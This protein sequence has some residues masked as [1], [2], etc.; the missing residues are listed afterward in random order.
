MAAKVGSVMT[1]AVGG[2]HV[3]GTVRYIGPLAEDV[4]GGTW[5]GVEL[6]EP[7]GRHSG[8]RYFACAERH[9]LFVRA[10]AAAAAMVAHLTS[11]PRGPIY[12]QYE[13]GI[14]TAAAASGVPF[15]MPPPH[16][17]GAGDALILIDLQYDYLPGG[18]FGVPEGNDVL[19]S[20]AGLLT[21]GAAA[22]ATVVCTREYH[23]SDHAS[24]RTAK[25]VAGPFPPHCVQGSR[26]ARLAAPIAAAAAAA[27]KATPDR[28]EIAFKGFHRDVDS[29]ACFEYPGALAKGRLV[30]RPSPDP[31]ALLGWT[32]S[33]VMRS[34][35]LDEDINAPPDVL[36]HAAG[37]ALTLAERLGPVKV[38]FLAGLAL[39][40]SACKCSPRR[41]RPTGALPC[42][43]GARL[44]RPRLG[45]HSARK[46]LPGGIHHQRLWSPL[47]AS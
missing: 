1:F 41:H 5:L 40:S 42:R 18:A 17:L 46:G 45:A 37:G 35:A 25:P 3:T 14:K 24:F 11:P 15:V 39:H 4:T 26:G 22:G 30:Q 27:R 32:G 33:L 23:P 8:R 36:A 7:I 16:R 2:N 6:S 44:L 12:T 21:A 20:L 19:A 47:S 10:S 29:F 28:V 9:G 13:A 38:L 31:G 43:L 34:S